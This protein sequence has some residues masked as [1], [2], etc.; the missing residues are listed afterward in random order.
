MKKFALLLA[1]LVLLL[2]FVL[3]GTVLASG[4]GIFAGG[5][6]T[7]GDPF[8]IEN[9]HHLNNVRG[10]LGAHFRLNANLGTTTDGYVEHASN[11]ADGGKGW[12]PIGIFS[13]SPFTGT[14]NGNGHTITGLFINRP[15]TN[16]VG[17]FGATDS[18]AK[19]FNVGLANVVVTGGFSVG[20][21]V[22][23]NGGTI[24]N[25]YATGAVTGA[26]TVGGL[27]GTNMGNITNSYATGVVTGSNVGGLVGESSS[28]GTVTN[29]YATGAVTGTN[30]NVGGLMGFNNLGTIINSYYN[31]DTTGHDDRGKGTPKTSTEMVH[32]STFSG[33]EDDFDDV[34][35]IDEGASYP[36]HSW[37]VPDP[38]P[39]PPPVTSVTLAP[40]SLTLTY[41]G[42]TETLVATVEPPGALPSVTWSSDATGVATVDAGGVVTP[43]GAGTA[44]I[45][46]TSVSNPSEEYTATV[47]VNKKEL[48]I[49]GSFTAS[50]KE[51]DGTTNAVIQDNSLSLTGIVD[52][53]DVTLTPAAAFADAN[54]GTA[55][56]VNLTGSSLGGDHAGNYTLSLTGAPTATANIT[57]KELTIGGSFTANDKEYD[58]NTAATIATNSLSLTDIVDGDDVTLVPVAAF[59]DANADTGKTV[60]LTDASSLGGDHAGNYTLS[61]TSAPTTTAD[62]TAKALT[63]TAESKVYGSDDP[64]FTVSYDGFVTGEDET[65]LGGTLAF[66]RAPGETAGTYTI[67]PSGLTSANYDITFVTGTLTI[68][69]APPPT[70]GDEG[71]YSPPP[72]APPAPEPGVSV[73]ESVSPERT[74]TAAGR[75]RDTVTVPAE[76]INNAAQQAVETGLTNLELMIGETGEAAAD[77]LDLSIP[78]AALSNLAE[79]NISLQVTTALGSLELPSGLLAALGA[80]GMDLQVEVERMSPEQARQARQLASQT[81]GQPLGESTR[82]NANIS[83]DTRVTLSLGGIELPADPAARQSFLDA[84]AVFV[85]H[86]DDSTE[87]VAGEVQYDDDGNPVG[88]SLWVDKFSVF[89]IVKMPQKEIVLTIGSQ[90]ALADGVES[91][92][93]APPFIKPEIGRTLVPVRFVSKML[94]A[95]VQWLPQTRQV[96][97]TD[98]DREILLTIGSDVVLVNGAAQELDCPA[99]IVGIRT[100]VPLRF[101]SEQLGASL[102]WH[103]QTETIT[104]SK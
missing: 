62:I 12:E 1:A 83:G 81:G 91:K 19:I 25:S 38:K 87:T 54:A 76:T 29:S 88:I 11:A 10:H 26:D 37:G 16:F 94:G 82:I 65:D 98:R 84:L 28:S 17:L 93:D 70:G 89:V 24:T 23:H 7:E 40:P 103:A 42:E 14:F 64:A 75:Q 77:E 95:G 99:E 52:G 61:L 100:F 15:V 3:P 44:T 45:T 6:G 35:R 67:T 33:W 104:I 32:Q 85:H 41:G 2:G 9:W 74:V 47:T 49:G 43:V 68:T 86:S 21:L 8:L 48:T 56:T 51:Y 71:E 22:G 5:E 30:Q 79:N 50:N 34:W 63:V 69:A 55:K 102:T 78:A 46:A 36:Y 4:N 31:K 80:Q 72:P 92:L 39:A 18:G 20:G 60:S 58:G 73:R 53:D 66:T 27:V 96:H 97:I 59:A 101:I 57:P 90:T 13:S